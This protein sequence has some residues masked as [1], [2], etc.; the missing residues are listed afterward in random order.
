M[1]ISHAIAQL[2]RRY[3]QSNREAMRNPWFIGWLVLLGTFLSVNAVFVVLAITTNP[4]LVVEDYYEQ[5]RQYEQHALERIAAQKNLRWTTRLE[6]PQAIILNRED[7]YRF[8]A[9]DIRGVAIRNAVIKLLA[10]RPSRASAD[11]VTHMHEYAP[12]V[13]EGDLRFPLP[14]VWDLKVEVYRDTERY[15]L[16]QRI[17]V[18]TPPAAEP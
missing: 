17:F 16:T 3:S 14:G 4:G 8:S 13:Y 9:V 2:R 10:Y 12:G 5:G 7:V 1:N 15:E 11:F 18:L 6:I